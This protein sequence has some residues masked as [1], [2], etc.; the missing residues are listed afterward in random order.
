M[1]LIIRGVPGGKNKFKNFNLF[2]YKPKIFAVPKVI[3]EPKKTI[4]KNV[5]IHIVNGTDIMALPI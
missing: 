1:K 2:W 4:G 3:K 5:V